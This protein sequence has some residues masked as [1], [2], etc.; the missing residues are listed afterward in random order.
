MSSKALTADQLQALSALLDEALDL[1]P[2]SHGDWLAD[3][4][5][6]APDLHER[7]SQ[8]LAMRA[9]GT[10]TGPL[11]EYALRALWE[12]PAAGMGRLRAGEAV[13]PYRLLRELGTGGMATVWLATRADGAFQ[14]QVALKLPQLSRLQPTL[15]DRFA[16]ERDILAKLEHPNIARFYDAGI[17]ADGLPYMAMEFV[18]GE[19]IT[20]GCD[21]VCMPLAGRLRLFLQVLDAI[22]YAHANLVIHRDLKPSNILVNGEGQ[23][24]VLD[25]GIAKLIAGEGADDE[26]TRAAGRALTMAYASPEQVRG[27]PLSTASDLY[28]LGVVLFELLAGGRPYTL[29]SATPAQL[30]AAILE[31]APAR[32]GTV[33]ARA[34]GA[35]ERA[36]RRGGTPARLGRELDG[37]LASV[38]RKTLAKQPGERY[39]SCAALR[40]DLRAYLEGRTVAAQPESRLYLAR[41]FVGRNRI[42]V[43]SAAGVLVAVLAGAGLS[44]WQ[45]GVAREQARRA[46]EQE[47]RAVA[48]QDFLLG[49]FRSNADAQPDPVRARE[50]TARE[51]LDIGAARLRGRLDE[52]PAA[53]DAVL[54]TL[55][56]MYVDVGLDKQAADLSGDRVALRERMYGADDPRVAE[57]LVDQVNAID[58]TTEA[59][60]AGALLARARRIVD[61][62]PA[63][64]TELRLRV[65]FAQAQITRYTDTSAS[66][67]FVQQARA[68]MRQTGTAGDAMRRA[69]YLEG[70]TLGFVGACGEGLQRVEEAHRIS[71]ASEGPKQ[72]WHIPE[73]TAIASN[74]ICIGDY[75]RAEAALQEGLELSR[76]LNG[77]D[78]I[79]TT[80]VLLRLMRVYGETSRAAEA[81]A[82][83]ARLRSLSDSPAV[84]HSANLNTTLLRALTLRAWET[85]RLDDADAFSAR[86]VEAYRGFT[87]ASTVLATALQTRGRIV[88]A[89]GR[90]D[91][92][93]RVLDE[94]LAMQRRALGARA[95][96]A[97]LAPA[98]IDRAAV[99]LWAGRPA[100]AL[101]LTEAVAAE[102]PADAA[103]TRPLAPLVARWRAAAL[104]ETGHAAEAD[105]AAQA[106]LQAMQ[107][108]LR[109]GDLPTL[110]ADLLLERGLALHAMS[111]FADARDMLAAALA[112]RTASDDPASVWRARVE[113]AQAD[114]L[115]A[116]GDRRGARDLGDGARQRLASVSA[117]APSLLRS[118]SGSP[119]NERRQP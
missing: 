31:A 26:L 111:R 51:L 16:R 11:G 14:R 30:E 75:A 119:A 97:A 24:R 9:H 72:Q 33:L 32:P 46:Q 50:T 100:E 45:A 98:R 49:L 40:D 83:D 3:V 22:Q 48:V 17:S 34:D 58:S 66:L 71:L 99:A 1:D 117:V 67:A 36:R 13:G 15:A 59:N 54:S 29:P 12:M 70:L 106:G 118:P 42:A 103:E 55:S 73:T 110:R 60:R 23:V 64:T 21:A 88:G 27:E 20:A 81:S 94:A 77:P 41:K 63:A 87:G 76:R 7:I 2:A 69:L 102:L 35:D 61:R 113:L 108:P 19:T 65:V 18:E 52:T 8:L 37:D 44:L 25:F 104:R 82:I 6:R 84:Q 114:T 107:P 47:A 79:D 86:M 115:A 5:R 93:T 10:S 39:D 74:A 78:H 109:A 91:D 92:A 43:A 4:A 85:G 80:H 28:S 38:L 89:T 116:L 68:L 62:S 95:T 96:P 105:A 90:L 101:A 112:L 57:A 56:D 53:K